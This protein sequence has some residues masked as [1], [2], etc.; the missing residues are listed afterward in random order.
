M[1]SG[2]CAGSAVGGKRSRV[3]M[4]R[5]LD[6]IEAIRIVVGRA[7]GAVRHEGAA[8]AADLAELAFRTAA[9]EILDA[10]AA[11]VR[12]CARPLPD[13]GQ[14]LLAN[15]AFDESVGLQRETAFHVSVRFD[16]DGQTS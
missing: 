13:S 10:E 3:R 14:R 7:R 4:L 2:G 5:P 16:A 15:V 9:V 8:A 6:A 1:P 11:G 12:E